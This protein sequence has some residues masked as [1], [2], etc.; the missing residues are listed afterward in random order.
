LKTLNV[1][2]IG[3][4]VW[5]RNH[6][7]V[8][9]QIPFTNLHTISDIDENRV[10]KI[11]QL[12]GSEY[13]TDVDKLIE[14][15]EIEL[16]SICTPTVTHAEIALKALEAGKHVLVE[17]PMTDTL[18]EAKSLIAMAEKKGLKLTVGF[19]ERFN[20]AVDKALD[21]VKADTIGDVILAHTRR[22][23]RRPLRIGDV[24]VIKDLAVHDI[25]VIC[26]LF[27]NE[28][29]KVFCIAGSIAHSFEDYANINLQYSGNRNAFIETNWL[30]PRIRRDLFITGSEGIISVS[31][32]T[33]EVIIETNEKLEQPFLKYE[34]PLYRELESFSEAVIED[35]L[36]VVSG[37]DGYKTL[38]ICTAALRSAENGE[39][40]DYKGIK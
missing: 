39:T 28:P 19:V 8:Y 17:K 7:R 24:G 9:R 27:P 15:P 26:Q 34:E 3:C 31:Y 32:R 37:Q 20:P 23:S 29:E 16:V 40:V 38:R 2:V 13:T 35:T 6:A 22:V 30:T 21:L 5:G 25:D 11:A 33:Q 36:P 10:K 4:G 1:G 12:N 14:D 18:A